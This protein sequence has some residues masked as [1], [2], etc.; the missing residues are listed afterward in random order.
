MEMAKR[1][2][3][4]GKRF[5]SFMLSEENY[6]IDILKVKEIM[7]MSAITRIPQAPEFLRGI[8]DL[9]G[10]IIPIIDLRLKFG[11]PFREYTKRTS[12]IV[13]EVMLQNEL[14]LMGLIVDMIQEVVGI[15]EDKIKKIAC[16]STKIRSDFIQGIAE[17][18]DGIKI[19]LDITRV[20]NENE[21]VVLKNFN[22]TNKG[23]KI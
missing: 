19:V 17:T 18:A 12:I 7:G 8:I 10:Q 13:V 6:C 23:E 4:T 16:L 1:K 9:R 2:M 11:R 15:P 21:F 3:M 20:L 22:D 14:A 5:L